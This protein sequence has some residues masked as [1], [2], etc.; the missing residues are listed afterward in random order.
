MQLEVGFEPVD[1]AAKE[2][3]LDCRYQARIDCAPQDQLGDEF[4]HLE[5]IGEMRQEQVGP[6]FAVDVLLQEL[7]EG[8]LRLPIVELARAP[9]RVIAVG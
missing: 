9:R 6:A 8:A 3:T 2:H 7:Q 5:P 1:R 4:L